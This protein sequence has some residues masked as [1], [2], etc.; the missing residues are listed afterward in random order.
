METE[1]EGVFFYIADSFNSLLGG[2]FVLPINKTPM[3][4]E[5]SGKS[6]CVIKD[7]SAFLIF[8]IF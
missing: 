2:S 4:E 5:K 6:A 8:F 7:I 3:Q 1:V